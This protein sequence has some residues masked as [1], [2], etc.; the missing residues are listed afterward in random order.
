MLL[1]LVGSL[2]S[3]TQYVLFSTA[4]RRQ[5]P[6]HLP[7]LRHTRT[8][9]LSGRSYTKVVLGPLRWY[10]ALLTV[11]T[12]FTLCNMHLKLMHFRSN[13][14]CILGRFLVYIE[15]NLNAKRA[16]SSVDF[17]CKMQWFLI[18]R[19]VKSSQILSLSIVVYMR[20]VSN[21]RKIYVQYVIKTTAF[22][23]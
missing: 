18:Y 5:G 21:I 13:F 19:L 17:I 4:S 6:V 2:K 11:P 20:F 3:Y 1:K 9:E 14:A 10:R 8:L 15:L 12:V 7:L 23:I 16:V 22:Y